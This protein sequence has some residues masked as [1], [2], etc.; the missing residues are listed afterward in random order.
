MP[1]PLKDPDLKHSKVIIY[2]PEE[3]LSELD[4]IAAQEYKSRNE[5]IRAAVRDYLRL[6][7]TKHITNS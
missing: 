5:S 2:I 6:L 1:R 4:A 3:L 7:N